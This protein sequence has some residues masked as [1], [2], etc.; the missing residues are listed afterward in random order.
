MYRFE[1]K[2][3]HYHLRRIQKPFFQSN[4]E[5]N[6]VFLNRSEEKHTEGR[7]FGAI[8]KSGV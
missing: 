3:L 5:L 6:Q 7:T 1:E 8:V 2:I 4:D